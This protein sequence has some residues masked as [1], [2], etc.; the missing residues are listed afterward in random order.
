MRNFIITWEPASIAVTCNQ[1]KVIG[2]VS[3]DSIGTAR[4][5][6]ARDASEYAAKY[7]EGNIYVLELPTRPDVCVFASGR[8]W[9]H[10]IGDIY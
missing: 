10:R 3:A 2:A 5:A 7:G 1:V 8:V 6:L 4:K 9:G